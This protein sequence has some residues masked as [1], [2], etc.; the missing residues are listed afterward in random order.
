MDTYRRI[1]VVTG[2]F[3]ILAALTSIVA[4][5]LYGPILTDADYILAAPAAD[6]RVLW[7]AVLEILAVISVVGT[8]VAIYPVTRQYRES[9]ALGY[10]CGR[11]FE[12][13]IIAVG[14]ISLLSIL[15]LR[16]HGATDP[17]DSASLVTA[18]RLLVAVHDWT[19]LFGPNVALGPNTLMLAYVMLRSRLVPRPIAILGLVGGVMVFFSGMAVLFGLFDQLSAWGGLVSLPVFAWEMSLAAW[20]IGKGFRPAA[21]HP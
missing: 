19:F 13:T 17:S 16:Q 9:L 3:F 14:I 8:A 10:V 11:L 12:G 4:L 2:G 18:G 1:A 20:L 15:T 5:L 7:G 21:R 6:S